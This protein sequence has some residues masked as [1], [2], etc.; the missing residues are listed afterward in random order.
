[1]R[2]EATTRRGLRGRNSGPGLALLAAGVLSPF[3]SFA[4]SAQTACAGPDSLQAAV[5]NHPNADSYA[6]LGTWFGERRRFD[7]ANAAFRSALRLDPDSA[8]LNYFLAFSLYSAG[9]PEQA[10]APLRRSIAASPKALQPRLLLAGILHRLG[11]TDEE[12]AQWKAALAIDP[13]SLDALDGLANLLTDGGDALAAIDLLSRSESPRDEDLTLDLARAYGVAGMLDQAAS[14]VKEAMAADP[15]SLRLANA[16]TTIYVQQRR[17]QDAAALMREYVQQ[18]PADVPARISLLRAL[19][20]NN[21]NDE[22]QPLA[23]KLLAA[24]PHDFDLLYLSG[25]LEREAG[26]YAT[27]RDHLL[28]AI[29][30]QPNDYSSRYNLGAALAH[31]ND[32][33]AAKRQLEKAVALDPT[34]SEARFQL[35]AVLRTLGETAAAQE[36]L[37]AYQRLTKANADRALAGEKAQMAAQKLEAGDTKEAVALYREAVA[38]TPENPLLQYKLSAALDQAGDTAGERAA[39]E[40]AVKFDPTLA[41]AQNQLGYLLSAEGSQAAAEEHFRAAVKAAPEFANAWLNLAATLGA[42]SR[43]AEARKAVDTALRLD[44]ENAQ[45]LQLSK[46]IEAAGHR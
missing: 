25:V 27:A 40:Q 15:S 4:A 39:L 21:S 6:E 8:K 24:S 10:V 44:P 33:P 5:R 13:A 28:D 35:A 11:R 38:A 46:Q 41:L 43:Y 34:Q 19:V 30:L 1:M 14:T 37:K 26:D 2:D 22:A 45:A 31:L 9:K 3:F 29:K 23:R 42:E 20:L 12:E 17:F 18:H 7:C 16:L 32:A 36:Q